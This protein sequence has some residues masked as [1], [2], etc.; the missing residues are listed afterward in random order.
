MDIINS[1][2]R[3]KFYENEKNSG[4]GLTKSQ[5]IE[6][7]EGEICGFVDPDDAILPNAIE[8]AMQVFSN[9]PEVVLTY[10]RFVTRDKDLKP[11][12]PFKAAMQVP[13]NDRFFF[14]YPVKIAHFVNFRKEVYEKNEKMNP[15]FQ[16]SEDQDLYLKMYEKGKVIFIDDSNYLYRKHDGGISQN[17]NKKKS[18][19]FW[20]E[21]IFDAIKRRRIKIING[22][23][24]PEKF[25]GEEEIFALLDYQNGIKFRILK[26]LKLLFQNY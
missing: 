3:V 22:K 25:T 6:L 5:L 4:V 9:F 26:K 19:A 20:G 17:N 18:Y 23:K 15:K 8:K 21:V 10:S 2:P 16:I 24:V 7:A 1:D 11:I 14:N 12:A 13:N